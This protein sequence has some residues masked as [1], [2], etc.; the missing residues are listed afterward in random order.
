MPNEFIFV[1]NQYFIWTRLQKK[2]CRSG[3]FGKKIKR[4]FSLKREVHNFYTLL[5]EISEN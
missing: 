5:T 3:E 1:F 2:Y 4:Q